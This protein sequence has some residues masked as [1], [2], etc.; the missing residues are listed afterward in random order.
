MYASGKKIGGIENFKVEAVSRTIN[1]NNSMSTPEI[2]AAITEVGKWL[3]NGAEVTFQFADGTY[4]LT[5]TLNFDGFMGAGQLTIT[6]NQSEDEE[7][8]HTN[9]AVILDGTG[10]NNDV[11]YLSDVR[12]LVFLKNIK[13]IA[14]VA[15][16]PV[17]SRALNMRTVSTLVSTGNYWL[18]DA[19][20]YGSIVSIWE[21]SGVWVENTRIGL[22]NYGI[23][24]ACSRVISEDNDDGGG[25]NQPKTALLC[26]YAGTIGKSGSQPTGSVANESV[27]KGGEIR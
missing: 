23:Y 24:S 1:L 3:H 10:H 18:G 5:D 2:Q 4:N 13:G 8:I 25:G 26:Q 20:T 27:A 16:S 19:N 7:T 21:S 12:C 11:M 6:G 14:K 17:T 9:Q 22:S 15:A